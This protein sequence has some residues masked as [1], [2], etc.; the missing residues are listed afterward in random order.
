VYGVRANSSNAVALANVKMR[1]IAV[2]TAAGVAISGV[3]I[4][5]VAKAI[6]IPDTLRVLA[7]ARWAA[8]GLTVVLLGLDIAVRGLR[9]RILLSPIA[10]LPQGTVLAH[11]LVG[12]LANSAL[13]VRLGELVRS[14]SLGDREGIS[15]SAVVGTVVVER[16]VDLGV[17]AVSVFIGVAFVTSASAF[18]L[19]AVTGLAVGLGGLTIL[20][21]IGRFG[22]HARWLDRVPAGK[23][24]STLHGLVNG[25]SVLRSTGVFTQSLVLS[26]LAWAITG[27]AFLTAASAVGLNLSIPEALLFAAAVNLATAIPAGPGYLGTFELAAIS[28][29]A[30]MG[31]SPTTGLATGVIVHVATLALTSIGG[32]GSLAVL[33]LVTPH[34]DDRGGRRVEQLAIAI[35]NDADDEASGI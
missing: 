2:R 25:V 3:S 24:R 10:V 31:I 11:L 8:V 12:Y 32:L 1:Q 6:S 26:A 13:P 14:F 17:L 21:A 29:S 19:A 5:L 18:L 34:A 35:G 4:Y 27:S 7:D 23:V 22:P 28:I 15:R 16:F 9:W 20:L 33:H 30:A